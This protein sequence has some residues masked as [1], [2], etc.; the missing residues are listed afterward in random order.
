MRN[1]HRIQVLAF[2]DAS[3][4]ASMY[5]KPLCVPSLTQIAKWKENK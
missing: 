1:A 2:Y 4:D 5:Y 3:T